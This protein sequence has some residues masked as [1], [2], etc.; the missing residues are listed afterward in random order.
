MDACPASE[1]AEIVCADEAGENAV[2]VTTAIV[3]FCLSASL[4]CVLLQFSRVHVHVPGSPLVQRLQRLVL[5]R[6]LAQSDL[7]LD[8]SAC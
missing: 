4:T 7:T 5:E 6:M 1:P 8:P 3:M 2:Y